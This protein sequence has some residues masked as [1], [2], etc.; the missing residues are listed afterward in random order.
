[1]SIL[2]TGL[3]GDDTLPG[4]IY[5]DE[6]HGL[7]G[8][9]LLQGKN[10]D[11]F[12][13]G[14]DDQDV[15]HGGNGFDMLYGDAGNDKL[16]G[17]AGTDYMFGGDGND[18]LKGGDGN[19]FLLGGAGRDSL[20]GG[21]GSDTFA[22]TG[23]TDSTD[24]NTDIIYNFQHG[25]DRIDLS[26]LGYSGFTAGRASA[27]ELRITYSAHSD[28]TYLRDDH[29]DFQIALK[30][31]Y[32]GILTNQDFTFA[33]PPMPSIKVGYYESELGSGNNNAAWALPITKLGYTAVSLDNLTSADLAGLSA[34][35][36]LN[37]SND[38]YGPELL[39]AGS[40]LA[41]YVSHGGVLIIHDRYVTDAKQILP[42]L[43]GE[44]VER[45]LLFNR[46]IDFVNHASA[47][48]NGPGG[49]LTDDSLDW[50]TPSTKGYAHDDSLGPDVVR[51]LTGATTSQV[52]SFAYAYGSGAVYYG[53]MALDFW[54]DNHGEQPVLSD[55][56]KVYAENV[57][58]WAVADHHNLLDL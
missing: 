12:L 27:T 2:I 22:Y 38:H 45:D 15:L 21:D 4:G 57:I 17:E 58:S 50:A 33:Q 28:R 37:S 32:R 16:Y 56:M 42:G 25:I 29:S 18:V 39:A 14:G 5:S 3:P 48:A 53:A 10:G 55:N 23:L 8:N 35:F 9:D 26:T 1:M 46:N 41:D 6:I 24:S 13:Y 31:D 30:G 19:D 52:T 40:A 34:V 44:K 20:F 36:I 51:V 43:T 49:H 7:G 11:D 47:I 54:L